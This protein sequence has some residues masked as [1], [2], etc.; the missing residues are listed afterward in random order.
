MQQT[1]VIIIGAGLGGL[2]FAQGLKKADIPFHVYE[3]DPTSDFRAQGY[4]IH[5]SL[6]GGE[7]LKNNLTPELFDLFERTCADMI[8]GRQ[9]YNAV[10]GTALV[11]RFFPER[12]GPG[13]Q[14]G[15]GGPGG[16]GPQ[17]GQGGPGGPGGPV[18]DGE[19]HYGPIQLIE[20]Q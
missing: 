16:P 5:I 6:E 8:F 14:G 4:R 10:D 9:L 18:N 3:R 12:G 19:K 15:P 1:K 7:A 20:Q 17:G 2:T 11:E 13:S